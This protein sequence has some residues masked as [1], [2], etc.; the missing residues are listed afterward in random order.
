MR[1]TIACLCV[2]AALC[3]GPV[4][5]A[6]RGNPKVEFEGRTIDEMV[7]AFMEENRVPGMTLAIVQAPYVS[8]VVGYGVSNVEKGLLASP[9]TL[10]RIGQL[11]E[12]YTFVAIMQLVEE[13]KL[14]LEDPVEKRIPGVNPLWRGITVRQL[15]DH[16]SG[17]PDYTSHPSYSRRQ[18]YK[19]ESV[20]AFAVD[21]PTAYSP[22]H[23][24]AHSAT[25]CFLLS[26]IVESASGVSFEAYVTKNQIER[27]G[28][29]STVFASQLPGVKQEAVEQNG[30]KHKD[31]LRDRAFIDPGEAA[32]GYADE[33]DKAATV[34]V[35]GATEGT[36]AAEGHVGSSLLASA[37]DISL[38]DIGLAGEVLVA[39]R[40]NRDYLY[41]GVK[42]GDGTIVPAHGGWRFP[43]H[44]GLMYIEGNAPGASCYLSRFTDKSELLCVT[45]CANKDG[46]AL[47]E[48]ARR[49]AGAFDRGLG[50]PVDPKT[51]TCTESCFPVPQTMMRIEA[52]LKANDYIIGGRID[53]AGAAGA[54]GLALRPSQ[55]LVF[56][57]P[58]IET[59]LLQSRPGA[60]IDL[61]L[62][63]A[64][65]EEADGT[66]WVGH[67]DAAGLARRY[68]IA[69]RAGELESMK[70]A[71]NGAISYGVAPY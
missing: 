1:S 15:M 32:Q 23:R 51:M 50:P 6:Q 29:K 33:E 3:L 30:M 62:R 57:K 63:I 4:A 11:S 22:G 41:Q 65:W 5:L 48:L 36:G 24:V 59:V 52:F 7:A 2:L 21:L 17:L 8:R 47:G 61:P 45:L 43:R 34:V 69:D 35:E 64:V 44:K 9:R 37:E 18:S 53:H 58:G 28:L 46:V 70:R 39:K 68:G 10:W 27:L 13:G 38:W 12:A 42:Q 55:V 67:H 49:I 31:F 60:A 16:T 19:P 71:I 54:A 26:M 66:V 56:G 25:D 14:A 40:E 20:L